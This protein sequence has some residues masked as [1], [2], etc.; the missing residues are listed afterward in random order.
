MSPQTG[1]YNGNA[2]LTENQVIAI[3]ELLSQGLYSQT[4]IA[5]MYN[6]SRRTIYGIIH[7]E[8]WINT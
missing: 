7:N 8:Y 6:V 2:K 4:K 1:S 3:K 5:K